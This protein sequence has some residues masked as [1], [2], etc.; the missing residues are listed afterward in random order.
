MEKAW[1]HNLALFCL[2]G[3]VEQSETDHYSSRLQVA[4]KLSPED[5]QAVER[6]V[7]DTISWLDSNQL[8]EVD[9]FE[10]KCD[11]TIALILGRRMAA[12][13]D[14]SAVVG[15]SDF[16]QVGR[17]PPLLCPGCSV[18][19]ACNGLNSHQTCGTARAFVCVMMSCCHLVPKQIFLCRL[20]SGLLGEKDQ[21]G[22]GQLHQSDFQ[23]SLFTGR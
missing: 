13:L 15:L 21:A 5:K 14:L 4:S 7:E 1:N 2:S 19:I 11:P 23:S 10:H 16:K 18:Q 22:P 20:D 12:V 8:A 6:A 3:C 17:R 9:E